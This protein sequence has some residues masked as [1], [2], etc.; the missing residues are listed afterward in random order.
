MPALTT[1]VLT[2]RAT[3]PVNHTFVPFDVKDGVGYVVESD[4]VKL[5]DS[6]FSITRRQTPGGRWK[7]SIKL[8]VPIIETQTI[9][10]V[11]TLVVV[12][13]NR[14]KSE[15]DFSRLAT[16]AMRNNIVGMTMDSLGTSKTF[17]QK[18]LVDL[19]GVW[20]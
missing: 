12:D 1:L 7:A 17:T 20:G 8:E 9:N 11:D 16:T 4:G 19:E 6:R 3:T 13:W 10:G 14:S 5:A 15:F 18:V 2:D